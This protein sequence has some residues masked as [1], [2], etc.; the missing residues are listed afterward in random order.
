M[1]RLRMPRPSLHAPGRPSGTAAP[2]RPA[3]AAG[4]RLLPR[5]AGRAW[6]VAA[7][8]VLLSMG[9]T[10]ATP[11]GAEADQ[12]PVDLGDA[13]SYAVLAGTAV[14]STD[15]TAI[16]GNLGVSP[17][18]SVTGFPPGTVS[19]S[20]HAGDAAAAAA[21]ADLVAAYND[22]AGRTPVTTVASELGGTT[23]APG[24]YNSANGVFGITGTLTLD[25]QGE[26]D[27]V[28]IFKASTFSTANVSNINLASGAQAKNVFWQV[29][30]TATLGTYCTF[31]GNVLAQTSVTVSTGAAVF[32]RVFAVNG[33]ITIQGPT[34]PPRTR[35]TVPNDPPTTTALSSSANPSRR[36][37][38]VTFT[39]TVSAVSGSLVPQGQVLFKDGATV[40]GS[41]LHNSSGPATLTTSTLDPGQHPITAVYLGGDTPSGEGIIH[42]A[43]STSPELIQTVVASLWT[44]ATVPAVTTLPDPNAVTVGVKFRSTTDGTIR[45]IRFYK[46]PQNT[47]T[48]IGS[49]WTSGG[50]QLASATFTNETATGWQQVSFTTPVAIDAG[51]TYVASYFTPTGN[52]SVNRP[53][54]GTQYTNSPLIALANSAEGGNGVYRYG[55]TNSFPT[56]TY[57]STNYWVDVVFTPSDSLWDSSATPA[58]SA[59]DPNPITVGVKFRSTTDGAIRGI[60][61]YKGLQNNGTHVGSLWTS[62]GTQLA[63]ATFTNETAAGWQEVSFT[64][65]VAID[66]GTTYVA[67]Y[68]TP[69]GGYSVNSSYFGSQYANGPLIAL[70]NGDE[71]GNGIYRYGATS[72]FPTSA[73]QAANYWVDVVFDIT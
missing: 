29:S 23:K 40:I 24:V 9:V 67:A 37:E 49:L 8:A 51:T 61:F 16:T 38:S 18:S 14:S 42:F 50:T 63:S 62:G 52:Y 58:A 30:G 44:P 48:H 56:G 12:A 2:G 69:T 71:G 19:G 59:A 70:A 57:Q 60:R 20:I 17:G 39:A 36:G 68:F 22:V 4:H 65:P 6:L 64:T 5:G 32:G 47:G 66:A 34:D 7:L 55:P 28:F 27:A 73:Y 1:S 33:G 21:K 54:F 10:V 11:Q 53:Y 26:P 43:P 25:A 35:I 13:A 72:T 15:L 31:R 45:G 3:R 41:D 46:G